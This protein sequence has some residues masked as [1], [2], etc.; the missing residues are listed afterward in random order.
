ME[1]LKLT[2]A[3]LVAAVV[4]MVGV[5]SLGQALASDL[6]LDIDGVKRVSIAKT[7]P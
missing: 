3:I 7:I 2:L 5:N 6:N 4:L 1:F